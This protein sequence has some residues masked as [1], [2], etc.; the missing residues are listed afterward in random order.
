LKQ[1]SK[2]IKAI[3]TKYAYAT[4]NKQNPMAGD[5]KLMLTFT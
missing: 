5:H 1:Y 4:T 2:Y 3:F